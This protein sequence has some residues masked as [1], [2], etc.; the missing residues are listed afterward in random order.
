MSRLAFVHITE[1]KSSLSHF[2]QTCSLSENC[3]IDL[4]YVILHY[5]NPMFECNVKVIKMEKRNDNNNNRRNK[6]YR[7]SHI[8]VLGCPQNW[9]APSFNYLPFRLVWSSLG[10]WAHKTEV[11]QMADQLNYTQK[12]QLIQKTDK[13]EQ[14]NKLLV[15]IIT[16]YLCF[17]AISP[18][19][20]LLHPPHAGDVWLLITW[21]R[22]EINT[23]LKH[24]FKDA[25][26][27][28]L[29]WL[30]MFLGQF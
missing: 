17:Y 22:C 28:L 20:F 7:G 11:G 12:C 3:N 30:V 19:R 10:C 21:S 23:D 26:N 15:L 13:K 27:T 4:K 18:F 29:H 24:L 1:N 25:K 6:H 14:I 5:I 8:L 9:S 16:I 2:L